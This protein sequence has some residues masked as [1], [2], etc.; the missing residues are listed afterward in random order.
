MPELR[1]LLRDRG[2]GAG[3]QWLGEEHHGKA[4]RLGRRGRG[5]PG[6]RE[7]C[8]HST[9]P[10]LPSSAPAQ[11]GPSSRVTSETSKPLGDQLLRLPWFHLPRSPPPRR[12]TRQT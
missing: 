12:V 5:A 9:A 6:G 4:A 10:L 3:V 7:A 1:P 11:Q 8:S 2:W